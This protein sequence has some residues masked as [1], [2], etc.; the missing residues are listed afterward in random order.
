[1]GAPHDHPQE[2]RL[3]LGSFESGAGLCFLS[4]YFLI[5]TFELTGTFHG[6]PDMGAAKFRFGV[7]LGRWVSV[8][9]CKVKSTVG[10]LGNRENNYLCEHTVPQL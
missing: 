5:G 1:M 8:L 4:Y 7:F 9:L 3:L 10:S 2:A 6:Y